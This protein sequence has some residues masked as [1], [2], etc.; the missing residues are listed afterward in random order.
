MQRPRRERLAV[1]RNRGRRIASDSAPCP[2]TVFAP[3]GSAPDSR[4]SFCRPQG[5]YKGWSTGWPGRSCRRC[6]GGSSQV[7]TPSLLLAWRRPRLNRIVR[8]RHRKRSRS[9][10][11][12]RRI[13]TR[14][15]PPNCTAY[16][17]P[18]CRLIRSGQ[19]RRAP[20]RPP[21]R[22]SRRNLPVRRQLRLPRYRW[23]PPSPRLRCRWH[24]P[25]QR[26]H[27]R[28]HPLSPRLRRWHPPSPRL[29]RRSRRPF[30]RRLGHR[31][32]QSRL[33]RPMPLP[34]LRRSLLRRPLILRT[35]PS[36]WAGAWR[37]SRSRPRQSQRRA[38]GP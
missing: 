6:F 10:H 13:Q 19:N 30:R 34:Q 16:R 7:S 38:R 36:R 1:C 25:S 15:L 24:P 21:C 33:G 9:R 11:R 17:G 20:R 12:R 14:R 27:R 3:P 28:W 5:T 31:R 2:H 32:R 22:R 37:V 23:H 4:Y 8:T 29:R 18:P 26:R 35:R